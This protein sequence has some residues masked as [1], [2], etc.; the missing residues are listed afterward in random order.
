MPSSKAQAGLEYLLTYGWG[1]IVIAIVIGVLIYTT[2]GATTGVTCQTRSSQIVLKEYTVN[3]GPDAVGITLQNATGE[4]ITVD[5]ASSD[6][7]TPFDADA[8][9]APTLLIDGAAASLGDIAKQGSTFV[10]SNLEGPSKAGSFTDGLITVNYTTQAGNG[11]PATAT[12]SCSG[13]AEQGGPT[14]PQCGDPICDGSC[15]DSRCDDP[16]CAGTICCGNGIAELGETCDGSDVGENMTC[17]SDCTA[18]INGCTTIER[19]GN[20]LITSTIRADESSPAYCISINASDVSLDCQGS[21]IRQISGSNKSGINIEYGANSIE[22]SNCSIEYF[23][24]TG[25][26]VMG[27]NITLN[28]VRMASNGT[29][30]FI[31]QHSQGPITFNNGMACDNTVSDVFIL[32]VLICT[33]LNINGFK[34]DTV[35][36]ECEQ[37]GWLPC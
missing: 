9:S 1:L 19:P 35:G 7:L 23:G 29:G 20:Y 28:N 17:L 21:F 25:L 15:P 4:S 5:S 26:F 12:I 16:D 36:P 10:I 27:S 24:Y 33:S 37:Q 18:R 31:P 3:A 2:S 32:D 8:G 22:I 13:T 30:L 11:M 34:A 14:G 6:A